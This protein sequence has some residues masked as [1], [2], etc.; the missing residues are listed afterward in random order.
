MHK[1]NFAVACFSL[2]FP[3][4]GGLHGM[5]PIAMPRQD[6]SEMWMLAGYAVLVECCDYQIQ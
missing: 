3:H 1:M 2:T 5:R 6:D 4:H